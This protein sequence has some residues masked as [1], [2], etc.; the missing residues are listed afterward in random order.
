M[1]RAGFT[2]TRFHPPLQILLKPTTKTL[3]ARPHGVYSML[4]A[5]F[6]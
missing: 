6:Y 3:E 1:H 5:G 2:E 4:V